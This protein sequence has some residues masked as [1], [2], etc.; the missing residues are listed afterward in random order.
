MFFTDIP[1][2]MTLVLGYCGYVCVYTPRREALLLEGGP[3]YIGRTLHPAHPLVNIKV[4]GVWKTVK[5]TRGG[6][7]GGRLG[8]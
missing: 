2:H 7:G 3:P 5:Q 4:K 8:P 1:N 6:E